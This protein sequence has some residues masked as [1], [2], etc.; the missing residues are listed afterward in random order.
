MYY[1]AKESRY[2]PHQNRPTQNP[3]AA[4]ENNILCVHK[5]LYIY[6]S[7]TRK[8]CTISALLVSWTTVKMSTKIK[9]ITVRDIRFPT[10]LQADGSDAMVCKGC[11][12]V[13][14]TYQVILHV[15]LCLCVC[16]FDYLSNMSI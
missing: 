6:A 16:V 8:L 11:I 5:Y 15:C 9:E 13:I 2:A 1:M 14:I 4:T 12:V 10:S 3:E 7:T